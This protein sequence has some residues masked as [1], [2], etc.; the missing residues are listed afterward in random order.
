M[1]VNLT[2]NGQ[3]ITVP[4]NTTILQA[5]KL[6][7][8]DIPTLCEH[9]DLCKRSVCRI[10]VVECD[11]QDKLIA[12][13]AN[14]VW[15]GAN[16]VTHNARVIETR[17]TILELLLANH[18]QDCLSCYKNKNCEL[19][20]LAETFG[21]RSAPFAPT[22][23]S[24]PPSVE[25]AAL[26]RD[27]DKCVKCGRCIE[28]CQNV[29]GI[30]AINTFGRGKEY[31]ICSPYEQP[32][33]EGVCVF[34]RRC[35]EVCPVAAICEH[36]ESLKIIK[37]LDNKTRF[38]KASEKYEKR[39]KAMLGELGKKLPIITGCSKGVYRFV[40][41]FYPDLTEHLALENFEFID[42]DIYVAP[43]VAL[44]YGHSNVITT[45][46]L[47]RLGKLAG[48]NL[49][50]E[51]EHSR[52]VKQSDISQRVTVRGFAQAREIL[53]QVRKGECKAQLIDILI[54]SDPNCPWS[55][56]KDK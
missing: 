45:R 31:G 6:A 10:C 7:N 12:A 20:T 24:R 27:M 33:E 23:D 9:S 1:S 25:G 2:I 48:T 17:R 3:P 13:C 55:I 35:A 39:E 30:G 36:D 42:D 34:C 46:E 56:V 22:A 40:R 29:Q 54:C 47:E 51:E 53:E 41:Q 52:Q 4:K 5:A 37:A 14:N 18:P 26:V 44:K 15:E 43:C 16:V 8:I 32:L 11:G 38:L 28:A 50:V 21:V 19:Q 49:A